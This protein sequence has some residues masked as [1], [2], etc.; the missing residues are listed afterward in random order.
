MS[1][2]IALTGATGFFGA[3]LMNRFL[4][5]GYEINALARDPQKLQPWRE[6]IDRGQVRLVKGDLN[7]LSALRALAEDVDHFIHCAGVTH[8]REDQDYHEINV[9]GAANAAI[10]FKARAKPSGRFIHISSLSAREPHLSPYA[11]S[12]RTRPAC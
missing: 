9:D 4:E 6:E 2:K 3:A 10:A 7:N 12:K 1:S 8:P 5:S 11:K